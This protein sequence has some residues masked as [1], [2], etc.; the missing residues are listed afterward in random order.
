MNVKVNVGASIEPDGSVRCEVKCN[1]QEATLWFTG[2]DV[3]VGIP[4]LPSLP[5]QQS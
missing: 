4:E 5:G 2:T 1:G 3:V